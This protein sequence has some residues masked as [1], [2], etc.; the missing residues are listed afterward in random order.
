MGANNMSDKE[1]YLLG[2][3]CGTTNIKAVVLREDGKI[4]AESSRPS[5]FINP[6]PNMQEQDANEWWSNT[7]DIF[8]TLTSQI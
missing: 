1:R 6:G 7:I 3:D 8:K 5:K 4:V 2:M